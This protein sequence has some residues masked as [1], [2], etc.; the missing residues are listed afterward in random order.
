MAYPSKGFTINQHLL[1]PDHEIKPGVADVYFH[2]G[3]IFPSMVSLVLQQGFLQICGCW[4]WVWGQVC[5]AC[6]QS[7]QAAWTIRGH[8]SWPAVPAGRPPRRPGRASGWSHTP[9]SVKREKANKRENTMW[10]KKH[11][12]YI[13]CEIQFWNWPHQKQ[14]RHGSSGDWTWGLWWCRQM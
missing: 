10:Y 8:S 13:C 9:N 4:L 1:N 3:W 6:C 14:W 12:V 11:T 2:L 5:W 7:S